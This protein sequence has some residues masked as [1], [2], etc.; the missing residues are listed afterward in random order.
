LFFTH[1]K[2]EGQTYIRALHPR[3]DIADVVL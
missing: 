2:S 3:S 1:I